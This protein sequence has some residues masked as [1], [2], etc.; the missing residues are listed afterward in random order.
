MSVN[1][2]V[3]LGEFNNFMIFKF[4]QWGFLF[5]LLG[6][7]GKGFL[8]ENVLEEVEDESDMDLN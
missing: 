8:L 3:D 7:Y 1:E 5:V 4:Q 6:C 2:E